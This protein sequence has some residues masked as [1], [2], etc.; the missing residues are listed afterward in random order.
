MEPFDKYPQRGRALLGKPR[1]ISN[2][3]Q[4]QGL[5]LFKLTGQSTCAYCDVSLVDDYYHWLLVAVDHVIP[6]GESK[7]LNIPSDFSGDVM[8]LVLC[9]SGCNGFRNRYVATADSRERWSLEAFLAIRDATFLERK[10]QIAQ[11]RAE[12]MDFFHKHWRG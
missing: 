8:N 1:N 9:C 7:R 6:N 4:G 11:R 2:T 10:K 5:E 3:R 12:E